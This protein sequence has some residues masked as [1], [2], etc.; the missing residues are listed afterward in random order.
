MDASGRAP[1]IG[2]TIKRARERKRMSQAEAAAAL[3]VSRSAL[4]AW[5]ND[6]AYPRSSIGAIEE[7]YGIVLD[8]EPEQ[9]PAVPPALL[10]EIMYTDGLTLEQKQAVIA[11]VEATLAAERGGT[12]SSGGEAASAAGAEAERRQRPAS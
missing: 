4:N 12:G 9:R 3:G 11:A 10:R 2:R 5:E 7:L 6:R 1:K 8:D